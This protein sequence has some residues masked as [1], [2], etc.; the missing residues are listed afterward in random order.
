MNQIIKANRISR[1]TNPVRAVS[2]GSKISPVSRLRNPVK[3]VKAASRGAKV[4]TSLDKITARFGG[5]FHFH[6]SF[7]SAPAARKINRPKEPGK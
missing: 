4:R 5:P 3:A 2:R 7:S 1:A 6:S